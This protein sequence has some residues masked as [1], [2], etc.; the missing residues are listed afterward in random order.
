MTKQGHPAVCLWLCRIVYMYF[1][2]YRCTVCA[3]PAMARV[4]LWCCCLAVA[5]TAAMGQGDGHRFFQNGE[6]DFTSN[7]L[8]SLAL[9]FQS[10]PNA[11]KHRLTFWHEPT[12][13]LSAKLLHQELLVD[14]A[15]DILLFPARE[16][17]VSVLVVNV[18]DETIRVHDVYEPPA[19]AKKNT[20]VSVFITSPLGHYL[21]FECR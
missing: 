7:D 3:C 9:S 12:I 18:T 10:L 8:A 11:T 14:V 2:C 6:Y 20:N 5:W 17:A 19:I 15:G 21:H 4:A 1:P 13:P 16:A